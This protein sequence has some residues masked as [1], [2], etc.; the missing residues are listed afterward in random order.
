MKTKEPKEIKYSYSRIDCYSQCPFKYF[1]KYIEG[2][3]TSAANVALEFGTLVHS[4][5]EKIGT[6]LKDSLP[7][8]YEELSANFATKCFEIQA[9][10]PAEFM[11]IDKSGRTYVDKIN[12]YL[13][14]GIYR[15]EK[16]MKVNQ[17]LEVVGLEVPFTFQFIDGQLFRGSI[18]RVLRN[19]ETNEYFVHDI[20][21]YTVP[22]EADKLA[23]P[24]QFV[25]YCLALKELYGCDPTKVVCSYDL[26]LCDLIQTAGTKD[27]IRRGQA[28]LTKLFTRIEE[29]DWAPKSSPLC[30]WCEFCPTNNA[31]KDDTKFL[32]PYFIHWTKDR[33]TF[34]KE[35]EW[36]GI[37]N[38][39]AILEMY[40]RTNNIVLET[41]KK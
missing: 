6:C 27:F 12:Y 9:R 22:I 21:T 26:P 20:K 5:E 10:Y 40:H 31:A 11:E 36:C 38:H 25:V 19:N 32:C 37:E 29:K 1:L 18:D 34:M 2:H 23:T 30:H 8:N 15:F 35:S 17:N 41:V 24:L 16:F 3:Y 13:N 39:P 14:E 33:K 28:K 4:T 7:I